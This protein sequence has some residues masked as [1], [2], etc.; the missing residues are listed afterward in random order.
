MRSQRRRWR[1]RKDCPSNVGGHTSRSIGGRLGL[2]EEELGM[3][4]PS[5]AIRV[6]PP[7]TFVEIFVSPL[8]LQRG[9]VENHAIFGCGA[10]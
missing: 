3:I 7:K 1:R 8:C 5:F 6:G 9:P 10:D 4:S 2:L